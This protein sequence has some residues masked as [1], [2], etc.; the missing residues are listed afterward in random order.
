[1][2]ILKWHHKQRRVSCDRGARPRRLWGWTCAAASEG[3]WKWWGA[4][5]L[6]Q[7]PK[8]LS[9]SCEL[10]HNSE[11]N[12]FCFNFFVTKCIITLIYNGPGLSLG[13]LSQA[14]VLSPTWFLS[15]KLQSS[16]IPPSYS[17]SHYFLASISSFRCLSKD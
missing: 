17:C 7:E 6:G 12:L 9:Y 1:M 15:L 3:G 16:G 14:D 2:P 4:A 11:L 5:C 8:P 10:F 13:R